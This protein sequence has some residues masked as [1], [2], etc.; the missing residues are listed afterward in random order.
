LRSDV[1]PAILD[2]ATLAAKLD[3]AQLRVVDCRYR[4]EEPAAGRQAWLEAHVPGAVYADLKEDLSAPP[5]ASGCRHPLPAAAAMAAL[6]ARLGI[7]A[8]THVVA[9]D[10][11]GG[12][13]AAARLWW[14]LRYLG[15]EAV[16]V[17]DGGWQAW[18]DA[19]LPTRGGAE[20]V[21]PADF[22]GRP[23]ARL[24]L[25][26]ERLADSPLLVDSRS[27]ERYRG[28]PYPLDARHGHIPG[29]VNR[30]WQTN[31]G[32]DGRFK[33][34]AL[35]RAELQQLLGG[36]PAAE[37]VFYCGSGVTACHTL[38]AAVHA[39]LE[40]PRLYPG[41]WSEWCADATR[42]VATASS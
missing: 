24:R 6:F 27:A 5:A 25:D 2:P 8:H 28:R 11:S 34:P 20:T 18:Q 21:A 30:C 31:L 35:L 9:Y 23:M 38:L 40:Q 37:A 10:A 19:G 39:G 22:A 42:P 32:A 17:L 14:M 16:S 13:L 3:E 26:L 33:P 7:G 29:A 1:T 36:V 4:L 15:H 12:A 41:S